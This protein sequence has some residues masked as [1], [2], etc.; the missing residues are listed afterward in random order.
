MRGREEG[1]E[2]TKKYFLK[3]HKPWRRETPSVYEI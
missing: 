1:K 2:E 3:G